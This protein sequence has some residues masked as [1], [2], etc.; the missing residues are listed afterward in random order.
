MRRWS[1]RFR[2]ALTW[3]P[4]PWAW[5]ESVVVD[6]VEVPLR[7]STLPPGTR[8][9]LMRG[10]YESA[11]R[12]VARLLVQPGARV[13]ELGGSRGV[14]SCVLGRRVG[15]TG[16]VLSV[17][18]D[19]ALAGPFRELASRN[20]LKIG[21]V[22]A[23]ACPI[24]ADEV[25]PGIRGGRFTRG[26][27]SLSGRVSKDG[28]A[29]LDVAWR[30]LKQIC[31]EA[32]FEPDTLVIDIEGGEVCWSEHPPRLPDSIRTVI[33]ELHPALVGPEAAAAALRALQ[34]DGFA[35]RA[36]SGTVFGLTREGVR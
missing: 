16:A 13:L 1:K 10:G 14:L 4:V 26:E 24:W 18:P 2:G 17:E 3:L 27:H 7:G 33:V 34:E 15:Q 12:Q 30:T 6:E 23:L 28:G 5:P 11:E 29:P 19:P 22:N 36:I 35:V 9:R 21:L 25:P 20:R 8:R 31:D 32:G